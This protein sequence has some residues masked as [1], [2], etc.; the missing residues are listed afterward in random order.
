MPP[1]GRLLDLQF[2]RAAKC[3]GENISLSR[4]HGSRSRVADDENPHEA[5]LPAGIVRIVVAQDADER[6]PKPVATV[7]TPL[8]VAVTVIVLQAAALTVIAAIV[9][10]KTVIGHPDNVGRAVLDALL[11]LFGAAILAACAR[12]LVHLR[13]AARSPVVVIELLTAV[14][15]FSLGFQAGLIQYGGPLMLSAVVVLYLL[16][17]PPVRAVLDRHYD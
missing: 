5:R 17:T 2:V 16:F 1:I 6:D 7:P 11:A 9:L 13:P 4:G 12:G 3:V 8:R 15:S 14:V 10:V